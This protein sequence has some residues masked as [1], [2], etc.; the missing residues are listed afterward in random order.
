MGGSSGRRARPTRTW[1]ATPEEQELLV[2]EREDTK[3]GADG[4]HLDDNASAVDAARWHRRP[5]SKEGVHLE[6]IPDN[7]QQRRPAKGGGAGW[8]AEGES[9]RGAP[10]VIEPTHA[11]TAKCGRAAEHGATTPEL[12]E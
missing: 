8:A 12:S 9:A 6:H 10:R 1:R 11:G 2:A 7:A 3:D 4:L 5:E